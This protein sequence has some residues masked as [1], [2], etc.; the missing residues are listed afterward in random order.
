MIDLK[1]QVEEAIAKFGEQLDWSKFSA[2]MTKMGDYFKQILDAQKEGLAY[3]VFIVK[4][5]TKRG[6]SP[7]TV[8]YRKLFGYYST[9][10]ETDDEGN[11]TINNYVHPLH[12]RP[13]PAV[14]RINIK[15]EVLNEGTKT[16]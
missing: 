7:K 14:E 11:I 5:K 10:I 6:Y 4:H 13:L 2:D 12:V 9:E 1:Q 8:K 15:L 3:R 16:I